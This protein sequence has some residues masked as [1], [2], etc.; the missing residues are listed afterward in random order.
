MN[1]TINGQ[2]VLALVDTGSEVSTVAEEWAVEKLGPLNLV[3]GFIT[4]RAVNGAVVPYLG[5]LT[6]S[7]QFLGQTRENVPVLVVPTPQD[8]STRSRKQQVPVLL[9]MN[10]LKSCLPYVN[11]VPE[12]LV[13]AVREVR[14][15]RTPPTTAR[16]AEKS[17]IP[18]L[19]LANIRICKLCTSHP[20]MVSTGPQCLPAGLVVIPTLLDSAD[21]QFVRVANFSTEDIFLP[22]KTQLAHV[23][24][25]DIVGRG[26]TVQ[27]TATANELIVSQDRTPSDSPNCPPVDIQGADISGPQ[28]QQLQEL[29][30][31]RSQAF[32][33]DDTDLG[34]TEEVHHRI[35]TVDHKP[36]AQPYRRIPPQQLQEVQEHIKGLISKKIVK[37]SYSPY[38]APIVCVRKRD[39]TLRLTVDYRRLNSKTMGDA[40]P[41]PRIHESFDAL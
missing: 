20:L 11:N 37:E 38:A 15:E 39:G 40:Y 24:S 16:S 27:V 32:A 9:G 25:V 10:I 28:R 31:R 21:S 3:R 6:V 5:I 7:L 18:A 13:S 29:L 4:L 19:S 33:I 12:L 41:L 23:E 36:V 35:R 17:R 30:I 8:S 22:R 2:P 1:I 26:E 34:Y 14:C